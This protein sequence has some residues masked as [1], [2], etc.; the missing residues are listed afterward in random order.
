MFILSAEILSI[1]IRHVPT[2]EGINIFGNELKMSQFADDTNLFC[3][4]LVS[5][6]NA[7][8]IVVDFGRISGL[9]LNMKKK[10]KGDL[11]REMGQ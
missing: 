8:N 4:D 9:Q 5:V 2:I 11:A 6:E 1:K 10:N 3:A 7:L